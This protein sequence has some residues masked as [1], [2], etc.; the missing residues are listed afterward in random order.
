MKSKG[1]N[2][3]WH[4]MLFVLLSCIILLFHQNVFAAPT[5]TITPDQTIA[6]KFIRHTV[7]GI[8]TPLPQL[9][10]VPGFLGSSFVAVGDLKHRR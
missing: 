7:T 1:I 6:D 3:K 8:T 4:T 2:K 9:P 5:V 10:D